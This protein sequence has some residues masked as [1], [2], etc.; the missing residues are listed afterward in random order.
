MRY[1]TDREARDIGLLPAAGDSDWWLLDSS[2]LVVMR[3]DSQG[4]RLQNELITDPAVV[5][6]ACYWRDL[7]VHHSIRAEFPDVTA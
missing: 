5:V 2:R 3:F 4:H 6:K 1:L 7:A